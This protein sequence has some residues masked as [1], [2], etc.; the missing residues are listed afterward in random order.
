MN[1]LKIN[2]N[3]K[4]SYQPRVRARGKINIIQYSTY[5]VV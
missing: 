3:R 1:K 4:K 2:K 5:T